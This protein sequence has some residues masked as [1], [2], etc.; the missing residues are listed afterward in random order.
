MVDESAFKTVLNDINDIVCPYEKSILHN[1][2]QCR[3]G[4][5]FYLADR[6]GIGCKNTQA[7][8]PCN[9]YINYLKMNAKFALK[10]H[11]A[12]EL[13]PHNKSIKI[14]VGGLKGLKLLIHPDEDTDEIEDVHQ[15]ITDA[16]EKYK[17]VE[18]IPLQE[19]IRCIAEFNGRKPKP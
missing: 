13:L 15:L 16:M 11:S 19:I 4:V 10:M 8:K 18:D 3:M 7:Q 17:N 6:Q 2:C 9:D 1:H 5:R 12:S 14:Q